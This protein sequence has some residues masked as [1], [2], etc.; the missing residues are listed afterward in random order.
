MAMTPRTLTLAPLW[1][2]P[3]NWLPASKEDSELLAHICG[4]MP[5]QVLLPSGDNLESLL[6]HA[7]GSLGVRL[8]F[9]PFAQ[10]FCPPSPSPETGAGGRS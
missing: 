9:D 8:I 5:E 7:C 3:R 10:P 6:I 2:Q 1:G 4:K